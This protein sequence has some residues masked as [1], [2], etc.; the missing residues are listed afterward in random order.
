MPRPKSLPAFTESER[1]RLHGLLAMKVVEMN[2][3]KLEEGDWSEVYC[4]AKGMENTGWS[5]LNIDVMHGALGVEHKMLRYSAS[6]DLADAFGKTFMHPAATRSIRIESTDAD[7]QLVM[8]SVLSQYADLIGERRELVRSQAPAGEDPDMRVGWLLWQD[9]LAQFLYF[10]EEMLE[11][12]PSEYEAI[13][14]ETAARGLRKASKSLW[15]YERDSGVKRYSVTTSAGIKIQPY[16]DVP[17]EDDPNVYLLTVIGDEVAP[18]TTRVWL[19]PSTAL[20][21]EAAVGGLSQDLVSRFVGE[22]IAEAGD[23]DFADESS[24]LEPVEVKISTGIYEEL[25]DRLSSQN[26]DE[27][28]SLLLEVFE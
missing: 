14:N 28:F 5:N 4:G 1:D 20:A 2:G 22:Q 8:E 12:D 13:W 19:K 17:T 6:E 15:I 11:P 26:D 9:S 7:P 18:G 10:E 21:L 27:L 24:A 16:F 3:R 23:L 25:A